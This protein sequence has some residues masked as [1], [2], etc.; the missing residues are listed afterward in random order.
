MQYLD[1]DA[2]ILCAANC[3]NAPY[4]VNMWCRECYEQY[5]T[6][7]D[8]RAKWVLWLESQERARR[9]RV[10]RRRKAGFVVERLDAI[11]ATG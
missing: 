11:A 4:G 3:G 2:P 10:Q 1:I 8:A 5:Q 6:E 9:A 7:I